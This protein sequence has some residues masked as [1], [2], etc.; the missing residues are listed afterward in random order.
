MNPILLII[1]LFL[2]LGGGFY[3]GGPAYGG[4]SLGLILVI[5]FMVYLFGG[6]RSIA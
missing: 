6:F 2:L 5:C 4:G 1:V 3:Y